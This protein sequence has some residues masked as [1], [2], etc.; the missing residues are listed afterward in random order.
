MTE[1]LDRPAGRVAYDDTGG[2]GPLL[3][4]FPGMGDV[5]ALYRFA[6][7]ALA[8]AGH[9][10]VTMDI[11]GHGE[12]STGWDDHGPVAIGGDV[13]A[14]LRALDGGPAVLVGESMTAASAI[15][16]AAEAP[17]LVRGLALLGPAVRFQPPGALARLAMGLVGRAA[18]FWT[19]Y[20]RTLYPARPPADL[21]AYIRALKANLRE[22]GRLAALRAMLAAVQEPRSNRFDEVTAPTLLVM[23]TA[24]PDF[25]DPV[26]E[27]RWLERQLPART[28]LVD[29]AG[30]YPLTE[31]PDVVT[32][33]L[34]AFLSEVVGVR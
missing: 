33:E 23:G 6:V 34:L 27:V 20:Y 4:A 8:A 11:R 14:L 22:P 13:L 19:A 31:F 32:P 24:D 9:R 21:D 12:S 17:E 2:D 15:W 30:H 26:A 3:V 25:P 7:P 5:R 28:L 1:F 18:G 10:V 16:V 29:G